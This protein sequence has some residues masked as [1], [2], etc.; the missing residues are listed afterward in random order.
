MT[1]GAFDTH[2][3]IQFEQFDADRDEVLERCWD[4]GMAGMLVVGTDIPSSLAAIELAERDERLW[5][6]AGVHP[7]DASDYSEEAEDNLRAMAESGKIVA[8]GEVGLDFYRNLSTRDA[9]ENAFRRQL[10]LA[11]EYDLPVVIHTREAIDEATEILTRWVE[12]LPAFRSRPPGVMHCFSGDLA[13]AERLVALGFLISIPATI[14]YPKNDEQ[15]RV[16]AALPL[17]SLVVETDSPH[18]PPQHLR[19]KRNEPREVLAAIAEVARVRG[20]AQDEIVT[21]TT[22]NA[23]RLLGL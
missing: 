21:A 9:Q 20:Q 4:A 18:L 11:A 16:A 10:A 12:T 8:L 1:P 15:R 6:T 5:A 14:T 3:H 13:Q 2:A 19:G 22:R 7:H 23:R 17:H